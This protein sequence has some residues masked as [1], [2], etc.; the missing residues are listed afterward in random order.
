MRSQ[1]WNSILAPGIR[2]TYSHPPEYPQGFFRVLH[3]LGG[4][5]SAFWGIVRLIMTQ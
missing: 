5:L 2:N 1:K 4:S 3:S